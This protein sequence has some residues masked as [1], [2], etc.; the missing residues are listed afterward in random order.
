MSNTSKTELDA[1]A[2]LEQSAMQKPNQQVSPASAKKD[3]PASAEED[4]SAA[5]T[6]L[7]QYM[8][9]RRKQQV[10]TGRGRLIF[11]LDATKSRAHT[12]ALASKLQADMLRSVASNSLDLKVMFYR[13]TECKKTEWTSDSEK[14]ARSMNKIECVTGYTHIE[15]ILD[16]LAEDH[17]NAVIFVGDAFE[18][19]LDKLSGLA[20]ELGQANTPVF[21]FHEYDH[22][23]NDNVPFD[24]TARAFKEIARRSG[25]AYFKFGAGPPQAVAQFATTLNTIADAVSKLAVGDSSA[26]AAI[27]HKKGGVI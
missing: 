25:G 14:L 1:K 17:V 10:N 9:N 24:D 21:V 5:K 16:T 23:C 4:K 19:N 11:S 3:T 27:T 22:E 13:G 2:M 6:M 20:S 8:A 18:E 26:I 12:W 7:G 15:K